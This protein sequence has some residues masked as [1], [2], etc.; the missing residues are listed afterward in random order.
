MSDFKAKMYQNRFRLGLCPIARW[1]SL[2]RSQNPLAVF[3]GAYF[4]GEGARRG[5][6][7]GIPSQNFSGPRAAREGW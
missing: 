5:R 2:Q 1:G 3:K 6:E 4:W 7:E